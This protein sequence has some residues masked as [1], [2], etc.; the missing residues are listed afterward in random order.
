M[1]D[2][3]RDPACSFTALP[4]YNIR[5]GHTFALFESYH[6][7]VQCKEKVIYIL[8]SVAYSEIGSF[9]ARVEQQP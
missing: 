7:N 5:C 6:F 4:R 2:V 3:R 8:R 9:L 1:S